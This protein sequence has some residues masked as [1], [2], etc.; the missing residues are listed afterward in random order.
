MFVPPALECSACK[1]I[2]SLCLA[3][4]CYV[5]L[6]DNFTYLAL[7]LQWALLLFSTVAADVLGW[8]WV[9][10]STVVGADD[11]PDVFLL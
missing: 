9:E 4:R 6:V 3:S 10:N 2:V 8:L 7:A 11:C 5:S 1:S